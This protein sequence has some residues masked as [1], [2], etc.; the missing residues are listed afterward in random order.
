[1]S[2]SIPRRSF[3]TCMLAAVVWTTVASLGAEPDTPER[4][5][6]LGDS[7]TK[8]VRTGVA[9][10]EIFSHLV[11]RRVQESHPK[12]T[13]IN[14]GIGG[15]HTDQA[16]ARLDNL[17]A[18]HRPTM[19]LVM[20]G[21]NDAYVDH[22]R[23]EPRLTREAYAANLEA[24]IATLRAAKVTPILMTEPA[25]AQ[26][27]APDGSGEHPDQRLGEY[28][29]AC[30]D[31]ATRLDV[32]VV[33][34]HAAWRTAAAAGQDLGEWTTDQCHP[35]PAGHTVMA[36]TILKTL[37]D[38]G[39]RHNGDQSRHCAARDLHTDILTPSLPRAARGGATTPLRPPPQQTQSS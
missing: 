10:D 21:T 15:E 20:Y 35:N 34:H 25:W 9:A 37:L 38:F 16:L 31:V 23:T 29:E 28:M 27:A 17:L 6:A 30:R 33:D 19:M 11:E 7:I 5:V 36:D 26:G 4:I 13:V 3:P 18:K 32:P 14:E 2:I 22:G 12:A 1:M 24:I 39:R 8:G